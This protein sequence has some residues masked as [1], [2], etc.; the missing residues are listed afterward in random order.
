[1]ISL[2]FILTIF[3][4]QQQ[5]LESLITDGSIRHE[6]LPEYS[7][8][9]RQVEQ[10]KQ[11]IKEEES[12]KMQQEKLHDSPL[13]PFSQF[14]SIHLCKDSPPDGE[15]I[16]GHLYCGVMFALYALLIISLVIYQLRSVIWLKNSLPNRAQDFQQE[17]KFEE[18]LELPIIVNGRRS[19][20]KDT[21]S[22][23]SNKEEFPRMLP[24]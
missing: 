17:Q 13:G 4:V 1:M 8:Y 12:R 11:K 3:C 23:P 6:D 16:Y 2:I 24:V 21:G 9:K 19:S 22:K 15:N 14:P 10:E 18:A 5:T 7:E 20:G